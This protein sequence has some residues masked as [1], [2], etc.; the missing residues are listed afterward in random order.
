MWANT[1]VYLLGEFIARD[2]DTRMYFT[3]A[4]LWLLSEASS[5][6]VSLVWGG[7]VESDKWVFVIRFQD[8]S[9]PLAFQSAEEC[10]Y[11]T[12]QATPT[13]CCSAFLT[14][15]TCPVFCT[16]GI[17]RPITSLSASTIFDLFS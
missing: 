8:D 15:K 16:V 11:D 12:A 7:E 4:S 5:C 13:S 10:D 17:G 3:Y 9:N 2:V 14:K 6:I 1:F